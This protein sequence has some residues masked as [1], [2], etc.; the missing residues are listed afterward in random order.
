MLGLIPANAKDDL[1]KLVTIANDPNNPAYKSN[2]TTTIKFYLSSVLS[3]TS[4][5]VEGTNKTLLTATAINAVTDPKSDVGKTL[6]TIDN[7]M[8]AMQDRTNSLSTVSET[9]GNV[10]DRVTVNKDMQKLQAQIDAMQAQVSKADTTSKQSSFDK[11]VSTV[12][13]AIA[14]VIPGLVAP[15]AAKASA[16]KVVSTATTTSTPGAAPKAGVAQVAPAQTANS[17]NATVK[18]TSNGNV[19]PSIPTVDMTALQN[20]L[21]VQTNALGDINSKLE[22]RINS[23]SAVNNAIKNFVPTSTNKGQLDMY[24]SQQQKL[25][26]EIG[27]LKSDKGMAESKMLTTFS[28]MYGAAA[29]TNLSKA[30][31]NANMN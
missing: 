26:A 16:V 29:A 17:P 8:Q 6:S 30:M 19:P 4:T 5:V 21:N 27:T 24:K 14:E 2:D 7:T 20:T 31:A 15:G 28:Q 18:S 11:A 12:T 10:G 3:K 13:N 25:T 22:T 9:Q 1:S 23:L